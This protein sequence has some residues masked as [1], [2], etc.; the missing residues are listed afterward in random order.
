M[1]GKNPLDG[2]TRNEATG[3][4]RQDRSDRTVASIREEIP[5]FAPGVRRDAR[6]SSRDDRKNGNPRR[7]SRIAKTASAMSCH[8]N[9]SC[10]GR[11][12]G[13]SVAFP[14]PGC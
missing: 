8:H 3:R 13:G 1:S 10:C 6:P 14:N 5:D 12:A 11:A 7:R 4:I 9:A 2:R